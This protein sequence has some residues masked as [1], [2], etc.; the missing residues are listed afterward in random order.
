MIS[1]RQAVELFHLHFVR[2]LC[3]GP[4][5]GSFAIKG[6]CNLRFFF[7]SVRY[8]EDIDLDIA[9]L[10]VH[11][12]KEKVSA[13]LSGPALSLAL[14][15]RGIAMTSVSAPKQTETTQRWKLGLSAEGHALPLHTKIEFSR[16]PTMEEAKVEPIAAAVLAEHQLMPFLAPHYPLGAALR[17]K[18]GALAGRS[19]V[20]AR[21]V[22][23]LGVLFAKSG[24]KVE[25]LQ[26]IR[27]V[28]PKAIE[29]AMEVSYADF[30]SQVASYLQPDLLDTYGSREAWDALQMRVVELLEKAAS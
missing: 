29:R 22:F 17:Q 21:D 1:D 12:L 14:R 16:R 27:S 4:S 25:A 26:P 20:Q 5:K 13:V 23:D 10:P 19:V 9:G 2:L 11:A 24:G 6:G 18:V 8:S 28:L 7:E 30:K 3:S 15:S